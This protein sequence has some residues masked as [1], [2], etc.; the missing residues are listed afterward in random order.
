MNSFKGFGSIQTADGD[1]PPHEM[2][3]ALEKLPD[4]SV[5]LQM[6]ALRNIYLYPHAEI[7]LDAIEVARLASEFDHD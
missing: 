1:A 3:L 4:G 5:K 6:I 7:T 2:R